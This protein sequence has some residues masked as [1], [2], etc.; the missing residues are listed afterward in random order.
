MEEENKNNETMDESPENK[1]NE[2]MD[3]S[4]EGSEQ[5]GEE[6]TQ[7]DVETT[8]EKAEEQPSSGNRIDG[9]VKWYNSRKG[10]GFVKGDDDQDYFVHHSQ[11]DGG[12]FLRE[13]DKVTF[14]PLDTD[15]GKQ[16]KDVRLEK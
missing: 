13:N 8:E 12:V 14:E 2:T 16:A 15:K 6:E 11:V 7:A 10:Y 9:V 3:E 4:P 5:F 1:N